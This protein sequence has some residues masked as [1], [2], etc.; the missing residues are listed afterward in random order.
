MPLTCRSTLSAALI[1]FSAG[2]S[3]APPS[4]EPIAR[5]EL[6]RYVGTWYQ[7]ALYPNR[8]QAQCV[9][10]TSA[11]YRALPD[12]HIE[13]L[14]RCR[15]GDGRDDQATGLARP[16]GSTVADGQLAPATL[17]VSFLPAWLRWTGIGWGRYWVV[18][19]ADDYRY[20]VVSEPTREYLWVL[21]RQPALGADD[22]RLIRARLVE[23]G[24]DLSRL[25]AHPQ[26]AR[27]TLPPTP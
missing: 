11:S 25:Q 20:A 13:V 17:K 12:G 24:F 14:N 9:S 19:L 6:S 22:E 4:L 21:S 8:F 7:V 2:A 5:V 15:T 26:S 27:P 23:L 16:D 1:A 10:D 18:A 3:A